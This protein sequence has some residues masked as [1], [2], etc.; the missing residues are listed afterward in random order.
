MMTILF[1]LAILPTSTP[2]EGPMQPVIIDF[3]APVNWAAVN[4]GVMGGLS[5]SSFEQG[6]DVAEF[7]GVLSLENNGGFASV[8]FANPTPDL[9]EFQA[10]V[11]RFRG[12]GRDYQLRLR[13]DRRMDGV[14]WMS[15]FET[16]EGEWQEVRLPLDEFLPTFRGRQVRGAGD[17]QLQRVYQITV[18]LADKTSGPFRLE[19][20]NLRGEPRDAS[21]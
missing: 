12:D 10:L 14:A 17:L 6:E 4:D 8:R 3:H 9:S 2:A 15:R 11:L 1:L 16:V 18:M 20:E 7:S 13:D 21:I 19:L 5:Q